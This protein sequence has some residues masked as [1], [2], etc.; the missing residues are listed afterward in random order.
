MA[1]E[2]KINSPVIE[3]L[4]E[5]L[6]EKRTEN[7]KDKIAELILRKVEEEIEVSLENTYL[8]DPELLGD[9]GRE[10]LENIKEKVVKRIEDNL[11]NILKWCSFEEILNIVLS[12]KSSYPKPPKTDADL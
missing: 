1:V 4:V 5:L 9:F 7:L 11:S 6:G 8:F 12:D 10:A 2:R 3:P